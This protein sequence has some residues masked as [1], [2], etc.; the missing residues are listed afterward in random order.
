MMQTDDFLKYLQYERNRSPRTITSYGDALH[1]FEKYF[2]NLDAGLTWETV[3]S[4]II[5]DWM[6]SLMDG[7]M[8]ASS[9]NQRMSAVRSFYRYAL[10][11]GLVEHDP[12]YAV[13]G[14]KKQRPLPQFLKENEMDRLLNPKMWGD[15][16]QDLLERTIIMTF[17]ETGIRR[18]ELLSLTLERVDFNHHAL[19]IHG[20]RDKE[21]IIP[22][23]EELEAQL[24]RYV[25]ERDKLEEHSS[26]SF[27]LT[28]K[29]R[30]VSSP[31]VYIWVKKNLSKVCT[32]KKRSPH[33]LRHTFATAMLNHNADLESVKQLLGHVSLSTTEIYTHTT[34]EQLK[35]EYIEAHPRA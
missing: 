16:Y 28:S 26:D 25:T 21:R 11:H 3:D 9:V 15:S 34:F 17:Y 33:V 8:K 7:G 23:G 22:M 32:L 30:P 4:D 13:K 31:E 5:R 1:A 24:S 6:E 10:S 27:F 35:R 20:K 29:G 2:R 12:S 18:S 19:K 14:P